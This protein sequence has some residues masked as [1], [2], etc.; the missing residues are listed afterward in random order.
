[1]A[2]S[3]NYTGDLPR[4]VLRSEQCRFASTNYLREQ[5]KISTDNRSLKIAFAMSVIETVWEFLN[6]LTM[7]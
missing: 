7:Q 4:Y 2:D 3:I 1:M 5:F 6:T